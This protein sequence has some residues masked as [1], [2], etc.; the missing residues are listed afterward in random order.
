MG[1]GMELHYI[2][3]AGLLLIAVSWLLQYWKMS[4]GK[5]GVSREFAALQ[6]A[7]IA[8]LIIDGMMGGLYDLAAMNL[9]TCGGAL[10]VLS[11]AKG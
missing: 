9:V 3:M 10:L 11:K 7:G 1:G 8:L 5:T 4:D 6:A 2:S